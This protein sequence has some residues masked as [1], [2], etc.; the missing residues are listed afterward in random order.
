MQ[1]YVSSRCW[2]L[3]FNVIKYGQQ[4]YVPSWH[5]YSRFNVIKYYTKLER[6]TKLNKNADENMTLIFILFLEKIK[7]K[8]SFNIFL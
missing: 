8:F 5:K 3:S 2:Y 1:N 4:K 6:L 7:H